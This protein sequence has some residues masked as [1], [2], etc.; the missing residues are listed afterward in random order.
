[1][2]ALD[3]IDHKILTVL[4]QDGA[5]SQREVASQVGLS[6]NACWRRIRRLTD[7]GI[8][9]GYHARLNASV[10]G[11]DLTVFIMIRTRHHSE[12]WSKTFKT[13]VESIPEVV[14]MHRIGGDWDYL[15]K[16]VTK[17]MAGYDKV[18]QNITSTVELEAVTGLF[19]METILE[20]RPLSI[21]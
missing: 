21:R 4:Q 6:Q 10:I 2:I 15:I 11:L 17:S 14:E 7:L 16:V 8:I 18:Y 20:N 19:S 12:K 5:L 1:M 3:Y 13:H 9:E